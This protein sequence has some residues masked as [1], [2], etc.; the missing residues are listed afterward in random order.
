MMDFILQQQHRCLAE[1]YAILGTLLRK[2]RDHCKNS[3]MHARGSCSSPASLTGSL[4]Y[5]D[6]DCDGS[7][8]WRHDTFMVHS[9]HLKCISGTHAH[10]CQA[11]KIQSL[12]HRY[13]PC[14]GVQREQL[15]GRL[16]FDPISDIGEKVSVDSLW[17]EGGGELNEQQKNIQSAKE[18]EL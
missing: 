9:L 2:L 8:T 10:C 6:A 7:F 14:D 11:F 4:S 12:Q 18:N 13:L 5:L 1:Q 16:S 17:K 15:S 3:H